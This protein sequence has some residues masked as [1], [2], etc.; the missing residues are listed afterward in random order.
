MATSIDEARAEVER[1]FGSAKD[2][3]SH[4]ERRSLFEF[5]SGLWT[6]LLELGRAMTTLFLALH[7]ARPRAARYEQAGR[8]YVIDRMRSTSLG[9]RF[10]KVVFR[11]PVGRPEGNRRGACDRPVDRELGLSAGFSLGVVLAMTRLCAQMAFATARDNFRQAHEW[12]PSP[13]AVLRMVDGVGDAARPFLEQAPAPDDDGEILVMQVDGRGAPM[14][15]TTEC[16]RRR[17]PHQIRG[18]TRRHGRRLRR[19]ESPRK[20]RTKGKKSKNAKV[21]IVGVLYTLRRTPDGL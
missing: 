5:E 10:G 12:A 8:A 18:G 9:T 21:A 20:R 17:R 11:R 3:A 4:V 2:W 14:I 13:R 1:V 7:V 6:L 19:R 16:R 15:N